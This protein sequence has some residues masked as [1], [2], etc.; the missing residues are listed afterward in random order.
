[1]KL[2]VSMKK[3]LSAF[4]TLKN[5]HL[6]LLLLSDALVLLTDVLI[7]YVLI[8]SIITVPKTEPMTVLCFAVFVVFS[9]VGLSIC[10]VY[11]MITKLVHAGE[12]VK[13]VCGITLGLLLSLIFATLTGIIFP[14]T[15]YLLFYL[16]ANF[17]VSIERM[18]LSYVINRVKMSHHRDRSDATLIIGA[19]FSGTHVLQEI[20]RSNTVNYRPI[21][22]VDDNPHLEGHS[23]EGYPILGPTTLIPE[24]CRKYDVKVILLAIPSC[25]EERKKKILS[26]CSATNC[27]I[28]VIPSLWE[29]ASHVQFL[30][31]V[32]SINIE[33]VL[34]RSVS[35]LDSSDFIPYAKDKSVMVTGV[36]SIGSEI[37]R[38]VVKCDI[39]KLIMVDIY[40]N[41][42]YDIQQ[43]LINDG[44]SDKIVT[45]IAS[46]RDYDKVK[47]LF[48]K[49]KP[50]IVFHAAAHKHVPLMEDNPEEAVKN[51]ILGTYNVAH[52]CRRFNVDKMVLISTD[53][54]VNPTNVMGASK[55]CCEMIMQYMA[56]KSDSTDF[57]TVRFGN[58]LGSNGSVIPLFVKQIE[59]GGPVTVTH[60]DIIRYFM[61]I[62]EAV[63]LV[64][65]A[66][67][68]AQGGEIFVLDMGE[69]FKITT[70]AE[71]VIK[72]YGYKPYEEMP[73]KFIGL[74]PGEKLFEE[75]LMDEEGLKSTKNKSIFIG[76]QINIDSVKFK[77]QLGDII[78]TAKTNNRD[79]VVE[80]LSEIVPTFIHK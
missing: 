7:S 64:L 71:N 47:H 69:P 66:G 41:N 16:L 50:D 43:E 77:K 9:M 36:G 61:T 56:Q 75:L 60:P 25:S 29:L 44:Y 42:A 78:E 35:D 48:S 10:G 33:D 59:H 76:N 30:P 15:F 38:Q 32:R 67:A 21:G 68:M 11:K 14:T 3:T 40:E 37:C 62:P 39:K 17:T 73:I 13:I 20:L 22:F 63:S 24:I 52:M 70:L 8:S 55:R 79:S 12:L 65:E 72:L 74:R 5:L 26:F 28:K 23:I 80:L 34:G 1:M 57:V 4:R 19:G 46:V 58:V 6:L 51:N 27:E 53:K 31:Q 45:E 54:A 18:L 49:Y 2:G